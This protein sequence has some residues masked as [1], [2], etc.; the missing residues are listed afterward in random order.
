MEEVRGFARRVGVN[1]NAIH[2]RETMKA[3]LSKLCV[4]ALGCAA[5]VTPGAG[6]YVLVGDG[7]ASGGQVVLDGGNGLGSQIAPTDSG[8][9]AGQRSVGNESGTDWLSLIAASVALAALG[10]AGLTMTH[11]RPKRQHATLSL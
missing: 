3:R 11:R 6:A 9:A 8:A 2:W 1:A 4:V 10:A 5:I 7:G